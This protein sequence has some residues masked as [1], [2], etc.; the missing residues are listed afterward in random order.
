MYQAK[1]SK[2]ERSMYKTNGRKTEREK[3]ACI[4][5]IGEREIEKNGYVSNK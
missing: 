1:R 2:R 5:Q 3:G 4:K